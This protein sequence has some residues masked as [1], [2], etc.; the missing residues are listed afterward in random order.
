MVCR[1]QIRC[2]YLCTSG[3]VAQGDTF[4][5]GH[6]G[7]ARA[8][9]RH[10]R[11]YIP[12]LA[13]NAAHF[14]IWR[15]QEKTRLGRSSQLTDFGRSYNPKHLYAAELDVSFFLKFYFNFYL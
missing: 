1:K 5:E 7:S 10:K 13:L 4:V 15:P 6:V 14:Q 8:H 12:Q 3:W 11:I 2:G 9:E